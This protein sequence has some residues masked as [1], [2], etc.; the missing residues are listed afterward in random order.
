MLSFFLVNKKDFDDFS[1]KRLLGSGL[2]F[3]ERC[4][5][6]FSGEATETNDFVQGSAASSLYCT[7]LYLVS[8]SK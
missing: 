3:K 6:H 1:F 4:S 5:Y 7:T 8:Y 2:Y